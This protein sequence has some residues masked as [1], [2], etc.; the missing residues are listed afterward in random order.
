MCI[1]FFSCKTGKDNVERISNQNYEVITDSVYT[2][3]PGSIFYQDNHIYW[4]D[5]IGFENFIHLVSVPEK[6]ELFCFANM[7][8]GPNDFSLPISSL[9]PNGGLFVNDGNKSLGILY[10]VVDG[11]LIST[12]HKYENNPKST[13]LLHLDANTLLYLCPEEKALFQIVRNNSS[14]GSS[15]GVLPIVDEIKNAY[16]IFQGNVLYNSQKRMLVYSN[17]IFPYVSIY[18]QTDGDK[19]ELVSELKDEWDYTINDGKLKFSSEMSSGAM[20]MALTEE[21]I[22]LLQRDSKVEGTISSQN[23]GRDIS[24]LPHSL[25]VYDYQLN[26]KKIIN[27]P[28]PMLRLCGDLESN[29][30]YAMSI[31]PEFELIRIDLDN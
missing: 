2:R 18:K 11:K 9:S 15:F 14:T 5:A 24:A 7:G 3:M 8:E 21:Y 26:L 28:F 20:E 29:E 13:R 16:D 30:V 10:K 31:N 19:W 22:V 23:S 1:C 17:I 6:K 27:M 4:E 25:F 12:S